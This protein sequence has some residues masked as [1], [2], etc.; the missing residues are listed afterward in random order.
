MLAKNIKVGDRLRSTINRR[1]IPKNEIVTIKEIDK[2]SREA[3]ILVEADY[4]TGQVWTTI[5]NYIKVVEHE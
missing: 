2:T 1:F 5:R 4:G 3:Q